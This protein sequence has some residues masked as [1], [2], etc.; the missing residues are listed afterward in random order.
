MA[1]IV[2]FPVRLLNPIIGED[3][4]YHHSHSAMWTL[5][6]LVL[7]FAFSMVAAWMRVRGVNITTLPRG[8]FLSSLLLLAPILL[9]TAAGL[10]TAMWGYPLSRPSLPSAATKAC[11]FKSIASFQL[12]PREG[13]TGLSDPKGF[14]LEWTQGI[15]NF[16]PAREPYYEHRARIIRAV[17]RQKS[18][19]SSSDIRREL[20]ENQMKKPDSTVLT[21]ASSGL[22]R[23]RRFAS[24][25][26]GVTLEFTTR[27]GTLIR[28]VGIASG[29]LAND[30][31]V[32]MEGLYSADTKAGPHWSNQYDYEIAGIEK[33]EFRLLF[34]VALLLA[35]LLSLIVSRIQAEASQKRT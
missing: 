2:L 23:E 26:K 25:L 10:N 29:Q 14:R 20:Y 28:Y 32:F 16:D 21:K 6:W 12:L 1:S 27:E 15:A 11:S 9:V 30:R 31:Y 22:L 4:Y 5:L 7:P 17:S 3:L 18:E 24:P 34:P 35:I 13:Q 33:I 19:C 8:T